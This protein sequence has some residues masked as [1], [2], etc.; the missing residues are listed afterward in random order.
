MSASCLFLVGNPR[1]GKNGPRNILHLSSSTLVQRNIFASSLGENL[2]ASLW[3]AP[4]KKILQQYL[5]G[6]VP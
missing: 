5:W 2:A 1:I 4:L 3:I 6:L